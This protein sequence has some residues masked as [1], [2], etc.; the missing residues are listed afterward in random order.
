MRTTVAA[1]ALCM[2]VV[3]NAQQPEPEKL[4]AYH[5]GDL[6]LVQ[7]HGAPKSAVRVG[8]WML[9]TRLRNTKQGKPDK[10]SDKRINLYF[11]VPGEQHKS[12]VEEYDH[13]LLVNTAP[14]SEDPIETEADL[15]WVMVLD[16]NFDSDIRHETDLI[17]FSHQRFTP[18]DLYAIED[19]PGYALLRDQL[20]YDSLL[21]LAR[22]R[23]SDGTLPRLIIV[24]SKLIFSVTLS[25]MPVPAE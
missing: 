14:Q 24:P 17:L 16:P 13:N 12:R 21:D 19:A 1:L 4:A 6:L 15:F 11:I 9:G 2:S 7:F 8:P 5:E 10:I 22:Y 25:P 18:N 23:D 20:K 3:A